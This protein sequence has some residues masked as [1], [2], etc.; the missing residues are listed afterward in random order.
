MKFFS[1]L[2]RRKPKQIK[3]GLALGSGGAKGFAEI[4]ALKAF[5]ENGL[6]FDV[7][8][9][10]SIGSI[11]GAFYADGYTS[12]DINE[13]IKNIDLGDVT[14][15]FMIKMDT[16]GM[17]KV[18]DRTIGS[19]NIEELK[20]PFMAVAT[21]VESGDEYVFSSGNV[22]T[23]LCASS[24]YPPFFKPV[25]IDNVRYIDGAFTNSVPADLV[26]K[27]GADYVV[28][29]DLSTH[30]KKQ[31]FLSRIIPTY[32]GKVEKPW[33]KGY[34]FSD[35]VLHPDLSAFKPV[36]IGSASVM[37][38]IGYECATKYIPQIKKDLELLKKNKLKKR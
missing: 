26:R 5:E 30:E 11:I 27:M 32:K 29:I 38:E 18:I 10:T 14:N 36:S 4:G 17:F 13:L 2:F 1:W 28:S 15:L 19:K 7:I 34:E 21:E 35:V 9:G 20:K 3:L 8:A 24:S 22:A 23:A 31:S 25:V 37:Y 16:L 12:T 33:E 6:E